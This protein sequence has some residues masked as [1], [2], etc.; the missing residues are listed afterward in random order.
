[1]VK[2]RDPQP[3]D[4][5]KFW[6]AAQL[7]GGGLG[8]FGDFVFSEKNRFGS[9][10]AETLAGPVAGL[11]AD[12]IRIP[13]SNFNLAIE[14]KDTKFGRDAANFLRYNTPVASS[15]WPTRLAFDR[16]VFDQLQM[17]LDPEADAQMRRAEQNQIRNRGNASW[18]SRGTSLPDRAPDLSNVTGGP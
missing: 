7:Q 11:A 3:M 9:G 5:P 10:L 18:W 2:G 15:F 14:G 12:A 16:L 4:T 6:L 13:V 8:I 17:M 1:M